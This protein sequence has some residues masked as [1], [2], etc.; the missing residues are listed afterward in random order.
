MANV[1]F[2][3]L[4][5][6]ITLR[7]LFAYA[8][9]AEKTHR[10]GI[11]SGASD[12]PQFFEAFRHRLR[13]L[14][15][16]EGTNLFIE[17]RYA[18]GDLDRLPDFAEQLIKEKVDLIVAVTTPAVVTAKKATTSI[19]IVMHNIADPV[20]VGLVD[21]LASPGGNITGTSSLGID[22]SG[23]R[24]EL[25]KES[26]PKLAR[27]AVLWNAAD[28]GMVMMSERIQA[29]AP[30]LGV[31]IKPLA[32][33]DPR[34]VNTALSDAGKSRPDALY[35][36]A[37]RLTALHLNR[38]LDWAAKLKLPS[39][40]EDEVFVKAGGL[41]AYGADRAEMN[42]RTAGYVDKIL[43]GIP[44]RNLPVEQPMKFEFVINLK[45]AK[46][47]GLTMPPNVLARADRVIR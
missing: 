43:K 23:K 41:M 35:M 33:R 40:F 21:S 1:L 6:F 17:H 3:L 25:L 46:Q 24:L 13:E 10:V 4:A 14:G 34:D 29:A 8:Q 18:A 39:V 42:R 20:S 27:V 19:P 7:P 15:H 11:L 32:I 38:V 30:S 28:R 12:V 5:G 45:T 26:V 31:A 44:P 37:D 22:L 16:I 47:I 36:I 9:P 2:F